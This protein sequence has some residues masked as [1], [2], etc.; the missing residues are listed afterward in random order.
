MSSPAEEE[1]HVAEETGDASEA[2]EGYESSVEGL[3]DFED[4]LVCPALHDSVRVKNPP[5]PFHPL[6]CKNETSVHHNTL[7]L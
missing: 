4:I 3:D 1:D 5:W 2:D 7:R 6:C